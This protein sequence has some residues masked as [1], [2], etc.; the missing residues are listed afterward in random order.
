MGCTLESDK[1]EVSKLVKPVELESPSTTDSSTNYNLI[2]AVAQLK[3]ESVFA[4]HPELTDEALL[5]EMGML[6]SKGSM[7]PVYKSSI[8][9]KKN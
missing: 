4:V 5:K 8:N 6:D 3:Y 1:S 7:V 2:Q 9:G